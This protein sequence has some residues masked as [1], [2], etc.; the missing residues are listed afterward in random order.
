MAQ[1]T[2][3]LLLASL[4]AG[5]APHRPNHSAMSGHAGMD[6]ATHM[7]AM[8][9]PQR[10]A[11][12]A[13][14]GGNVMPFSLS[15]TVHV[16]DKTPAGGTQ[17][18]LARNA[19][20]TAQVAL[21]RQHLREIH[22]QFLKGDFS[23]PSHIHGQDMPGLAQLKTAQPGQLDIAYSDVAGGAE[24]IYKT[25]AVPLVGALHRWFDAQLADHGKDA[26]DGHAGH[27]GQSGAMRH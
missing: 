6:H 10:Q 19:D 27:S 23:G 24:L 17:R 22:G 18:V 12:V 7:K 4:L 8:A 11:E 20:D 21:V 26:V 13:A 15:A 9:D 2:A 16:F 1:Y 5:C 14:R 25:A 3:L